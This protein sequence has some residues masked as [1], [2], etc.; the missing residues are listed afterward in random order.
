MRYWDQ[1]RTEGDRLLRNETNRVK[2]LA[3]LVASMITKKWKLIDSIIQAKQ[4]EIR[5]MELQLAG[6]RHIDAIIEKSTHILNEVQNSIAVEPADDETGDISANDSDAMSAVDNA[7]LHSHDD[8]ELNELEAEKDMPLEELLEKYGYLD[9]LD[10]NDVKPF[11]NSESEE[12]DDFSSEASDFAMEDNQLEFG[13]SRLSFGPLEPLLTDDSSFETTDASEFTDYDNGYPSS[14]D[15]GEEELAMLKNEAFADISAIFDEYNLSPAVST[16]CEVEHGGGDMVND[17]MSIAESSASESYA[18]SEKSSVSAVGLDAL[19]NADVVD[20]DLNE[21]LNMSRPALN[22]DQVTVVEGEDPMNLAEDMPENLEETIVHSSAKPLEVIEQNTQESQDVVCK[23]SQPAHEIPVAESVVDSSNRPDGEA[24]MKTKVPFLLKYPLRNYQHVGLDWLVS[25]FSSGLNGILADEMNNLMELWSLL[26]FLMPNGVANL[27]PAGFATLKEFQDWFSRPVDKII[28][29]SKELDDDT[30]ATIQKLHTVLRPYILRRLK[31][32]VEK[33]MPSKFEHIVKCRLSSRQRYLYDDYMSRAKTKEALASGNYMSIINCLMQLRKVCNHPDLFEE[34]PVVTSFVMEAA[35]RE[36]L[37]RY[38]FY[39]RHGLLFTGEGVEKFRLSQQ[40]LKFVEL[41]SEFTIE[42]NMLRKANQ[43]RRLDNLVIQEGEF[44]TDFLKKKVDWKDWLDGMG[45]NVDDNRKDEQP[46]P[47]ETPLDREAE[48][49]PDGDD[50]EKVLA[51][52]E[53][54]TDVIAM[55]AARNELVDEQKEFQETGGDEG[56]HKDANAGSDEM[57]ANTGANES[58]MVDT[59][60]A[61]REGNVLENIQSANE[62]EKLS[63]LTGHVD[64]Y[65]LRFWIWNLGLSLKIEDIVNHSS[66]V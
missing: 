58:Q 11:D 10:E 44:T 27:M 9:R 46:K 19:Y 16:F 65:M 63:M 49:I 2:K 56:L 25:L 40:K 51:M 32:E 21:P 15:D 60:D 17:N 23:K 55:H 35:I 6:K 62:T 53:D 20:E 59:E 42:E 4:K 43:K 26:Y 41:I 54:E 18:S 47:R 39:L 66:S 24:E 13:T 48:G 36:E 12:G 8:S 3:K 38:D 31:S 57:Q 28:D 34:R 61:S 14:S 52:A 7:S 64:E 33:Q 45:I 1:K 29:E 50:L 22:A 30:K 37:E 5:D